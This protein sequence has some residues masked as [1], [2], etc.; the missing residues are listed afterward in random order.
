MQP[1]KQDHAT[2][3][4]Q[5]DKFPWLFIAIAF[6]ISWTCWFFVAL[7]GRNI[8]TDLEVGIVAVLGASGPQLPASS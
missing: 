7:T 4:T 2:A 8:F 1:F 5:T 6:G 3:S